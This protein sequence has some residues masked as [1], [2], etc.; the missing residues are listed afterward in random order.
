MFFAVKP[1][2]DVN[3]ATRALVYG[4]PF[5]FF[6]CAT[7]DLTNHAT[8]RGWP[9]IVTVVDM[10]CGTV[11]TLRVSPDRRAPLPRLAQHAWSYPGL[12]VKMGAVKTTECATR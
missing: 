2:L 3:S 5:G 9:A 4:A 8:M 11:L 6:T 1:A 12:W 7:C 10:A